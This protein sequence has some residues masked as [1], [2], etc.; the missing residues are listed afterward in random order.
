MTIE[1]V[2]GDKNSV[3]VM[4]A[5]I[6]GMQA[7]LLLAELGR[8]VFLLEQG[9]AI[10][11]YFPLLDKT[12]PTNSCGIC[13]MSPDP[14]AF[15][16]IYECQLHKNIKLITYSELTKIEGEAG[17][18]KLSILK[19]PRYVIQERCTLCEKCIKMCPVEVEREFGGGLERRKAIY[20]PFPQAIPKALL[21]DQK[22]CIRCGECIKACD[23][24]AI[25]LEMKAKEETLEVGA[26]I[27]GFG[28]E[29]FW[30]QK[31]GEYGFGRYRNILTSIQFERLLSTSS[32]TGGFPIR[33]SDWREMNNIAFIQCVGSRDPS[34]G[35]D[36]C[37]T[38]CCMYATK[39]AMIAKERSP[40]LRATI[41]YIDIRPM[42]KDYERYFER[43]KNEFGIEYIRSAISSVK[44][45]QKTKNLLI[46]YLKEDG[47]FE[48][49]EFDAVI[50][51]VGFTPPKEIKELAKNMGIKLNPYGFCY[52]DEFNPQQTSV[53]G[54]FVAG[55]FRAPKDIPETVVDG[56]SAVALVS[57]FFSKNNISQ[58]SRRYSVE[59][60][61]ND[62]IPRVGVFICL[63]GDE[64]K[65]ILS[66]DDIVTKIKGLRDVIHFEKV[67]L[68]DFQEGVDLIKRRIKE[69]N[70]N[71]LV[72]AGCTNKEIRARI[73]D[74]VAD[75]GLNPY[76][77]EYA[78][79]NDQC[80]LVHKEYK[81]LAIQKAVTL[82]TM[83]VERAR[84][85][86]PIQRKT[87]NIMKNALVIGGGVSGMISSLRMADHGYE[88]F[89]I[90]KE[91]E[92]GGNLRESFYTLRGSDPQLLLN[93]LRKK[94]EANDFI[95]LYLEAEVEGF[96]RK[97]GYFR[98]KVI[99]PNGEVFIDH[100][101]LILA[102]GGK[103]IKP[104]EYLYGED[105]RIITQ[106]QLEK[107]IYLNDLKIG[108]FK[109]IAMIQC[110]GSRDDDHP[111]CSRICCGHA[112]KNALKLKER[113]PLIN[114]YIIYRDIR[115]YG[116]YESY[117]YEARKKGIIFIRFEP[118]RKPE[119]TISENKL[120][121]TVFD[122]A[123]NRYLK[124]PVDSIILS[125]GIEPNDNKK[126]ANIFKVE[127]NP[128]GFF[129][130]ANPK[131]SPLDF[132][133]RGKFFCGLCHSPNFIEDS[134]SQ[135]NAVA[136]RAMTLL[137]KDFLMEKTYQAYVIKRLCCGCG[138]CV[139]AC[140][141]KARVINE[142]EWKAEVIGELCQGC[143][144]C[145]IACR[146]GASQ[147]RNFEKQINLVALDAAID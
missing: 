52:T 32:P 8:D 132:V 115:T 76:L 121:L 24:E 136:A 33:I 57:S 75:I 120:Y 138:L 90:E 41:F 109:Q 23:Y 53:P 70:I 55:A 112:I 141:Y 124:I 97:D 61:L 85:I 42:G 60:A 103:E 98:T 125:T 94:V 38:I 27:L 86:K 93:D 126:L 129:K 147:Q 65:E 114:I 48:E 56:A 92:L 21:I 64:P 131:S 106:R 117:Y 89:L 79:I 10:G 91:K 62:E 11:G 51:S 119:V 100:A 49:R 104:K 7:A 145:V 3:L 6:S 140:P 78:N 108:E 83:A 9:P 101:V 139:E 43:A 45:I 71:R 127:L 123:I 110:V 82:I 19:K 87:Y 34:C 133:D 59:K 37:S 50:L 144:S 81:E 69:E 22:S 84:R 96:S 142:E 26:I 68:N 116:F 4:G 25:D 122:P 113:N 130:E 63:I 99:N 5:G 13:F 66:I 143:G 2:I 12:F 16:P 39:Q 134:I 137:S 18:F 111:Y 102:T 31:K 88:V 1:K 29:P 46:T 72:L 20:L 73:E 95:H 107:M 44:E 58:S 128:D 67:N 118:A 14:P 77:I 80:F 105:P 17:D 74:L 40:N 36:Y 30:A 35:Q 146:N 135:G 28:F 47:S 54:I 15:C